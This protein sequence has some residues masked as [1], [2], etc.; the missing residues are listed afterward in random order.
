LQICELIMALD[1][2]LTPGCQGNE[3]GRLHSLRRLI[4]DDDIKCARHLAE[5]AGAAEAERAAHDGRVLQHLGAHNVALGSARCALPALHMLFAA[6]C[7]TGTRFGCLMRVESVR[8]QV[9]T[10]TL[11][12][13]RTAARRSSTSVS[14]AT[15]ATE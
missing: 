15:C 10:T 6:V 3:D 14:N 8:A 12:T 4:D 2:L 7:E 9:S 13:L 5:G 1:H 11:L